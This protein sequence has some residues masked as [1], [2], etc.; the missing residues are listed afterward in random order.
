M[1]PPNSTSQAVQKAVQRPDSARD[2][3]PN[4]QQNRASTPDSSVWVTASAGTGKTKVLTDRVLRLLLPGEDGR[5]GTKASKILCLTFTKAGAGEMSQRLARTLARWAVMDEADL[6]T[7]L[8]KLQNRDPSKEELAKARRLFAEV[9]DTPG[10]LNIMTIHSFCQSVLGRF[11]LEAG[12]PPHFKALEE[13]DAALL[14]EQARDA[15]LKKA[16]EE[17]STKL[18]SALNRVS[19]AVNEEQFFALIKNIAKEREQMQRTFGEL[20]GADGLYKAICS[21]L[22]I[23]PGREPHDILKDAC[24]SNA[25]DESGL[26]DSCRALSEHGTATDADNAS[27]IQSWLDSATRF[28]NFSKYQL[29]YLTKDQTIR[30]KLAGVGVDRAVPGTSAILQ[31]EAERIHKLLAQMNAANSALLTRDLFILGHAIVTEYQNLKRE[32]A[33]LD[34]DDLIFTT[35]ALLEGRAEKLSGENAAAWVLFK[36]DQGIDHILVDEA[37]DTNP[38]QWL[39]VK[40]LA[41]EFTAGL[42]ASE[43][44]RSIFVVGDEKQSIYS[45]QRASPKEFQRMRNWL[46]QKVD[47]SGKRWDDVPMNISFRSVKSVLQAVDAVFAPPAMQSGVSEAAVTH[48]S[49]RHGQ[50]G[51]VELWPL[52]TT[53]EKEPHAPWALPTEIIEATD[54][55]SQLSKHIAE[56][57]RGWIDDPNAILPARGRRIR[58][59]DI[60]IL[61]RTRN[62]L[63]KQVAKALKD[64]KIPVS[65]ADRMVLGEQIAVQ[66]L[67]ACAEFALQPFDDLTLATLLKSPLINMDEDTLFKL[68]HPREAT[69]W[70]ALQ[71]HNKPIAEYLSNLRH[72]AAHLSPFD[73]FTFILQSPCPADPRSGLRAMQTRLGHDILDPLDELLAAALD[74][75]NNNPPSLQHFLH[76][77]ARETTEIRREMEEGGNIV[78]LM[79]VHGAKGL[80]A[81]IVIIPD[82]TRVQR[83]APAA[84]DRRLL[85]PDKTD[86]K[87][88]LWAPRKE[89]GYETY[90]EALAAIEA[91]QD[92][93]YRRL[94]YVAMTRAEDRLY[95]AGATGRRNPLPDSWY[96]ALRSGMESIEHAETFDDGTIQIKNNQA[97][98]KKPDKP[99]QQAKAEQKKSAPPAWLFKSAPPENPPQKPFR[100]SRGDEDEPAA[101]SPLQKDNRSNFRR[102]NLTHK[103]L[104]VL[105]TLPEEKREAA[106][107]NFL[108]RFAPELDDETRSSIADETFKVLRHPEFAAVFGPRSLAEVP[109]AGTLKDGRIV[110]GQI[111]RLLVTDKEI[112]IVDYKTNRP[113]PQR[114]EDVPLIYKAQM[115]AYADALAQIYPG[116]TISCALLWTDGPRLMPVPA[117]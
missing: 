83:G 84:A 107:E 47:D 96:F 105:P 54:G 44:E 97:E 64:K 60:M 92:D 4:V 78:R 10:G 49:F 75:E 12:I 55:P 26:R 86:Y 41:H 42:G 32:R 57:I 13:T 89:E 114:A 85:W 46:K 18:A 76:A 19:F 58:P 112:L 56:K 37:Q 69:L 87:F 103:L 30:K 88:P 43:A 68:A 95:L 79:T 3:D 48:T 33:A 62:A 66:D 113:P 24:D 104:E 25:F 116:R 82:T 94:L 2:I 6:R 109:V 70:F 110:S 72:D 93:E 53:P 50:G 1:T 91:R 9:A 16:E 98:G 99:D 40:A 81:P 100:P 117:T 59:G 74:H 115:A 73:F 7:E 102:G 71:D 17:S 80:Q 14:L 61:F 8:K 38:E 45:F 67:I 65:G 35:C 22:D 15:I 108:A 28:E 51:Q 90:D 106:A 20:G 111:D 5:P 52:F 63:F 11:P 21:E 31:K 36:L 29:A 23:P 101:S 34:F 39:V 27:I 77:F